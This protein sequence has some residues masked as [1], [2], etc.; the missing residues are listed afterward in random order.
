M[1]DITNVVLGTF[2]GYYTI[3]F[4]YSKM[5]IDLLV[6][7]FPNSCS[8]THTIQTIRKKRSL[9][10][11]CS[12][13]TVDL[14]ITIVYSKQKTCFVIT[15]QHKI[16]DGGYLHH[17]L[18][19]WSERYR[20]KCSM[21]QTICDSR[22]SILGNMFLP[23]EISLVERLKSYYKCSSYVALTVIW[24][25]Y[26]QQKLQKTTFGQIISVRNGSVEPGNFITI[27]FFTLCSKTNVKKNCKLLQQN[28]A[29]AKQIHRTPLTLPLSILKSSHCDVNTIVF[30]S[31]LVFQHTNFPSLECIYIPKLNTITQPFFSPTLLFIAIQA[32]CYTLYDASNKFSHME[33]TDFQGFANQFDVYC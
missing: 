19:M 26:F 10:N 8:F 13:P 22:P 31:Q 16:F 14:F 28:I 23:I 18:N 1:L 17:V 29:E 25:M 32:G 24:S 21:K 33:T 9:I 3:S 12:N 20:E 11:Y 6:N 15:A 30:D 5:V 27:D 2:V 4:V 7:T